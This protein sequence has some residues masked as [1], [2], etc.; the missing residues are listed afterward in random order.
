MVFT[1]PSLNEAL[2]YKY[3]FFILDVAP[4]GTHTIIFFSGQTKYSL[5]ELKLT[6]YSPK[7]FKNLV[8]AG[9]AKRMKS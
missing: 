5:I 4:K 2:R 9:A 1:P 3:P 7:F 8:S 6:K